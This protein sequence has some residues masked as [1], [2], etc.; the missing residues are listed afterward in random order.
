MP[1]RLIC[2]IVFGGAL[3][4]ALAMPA[5]EAL[6]D[7]R[8]VQPVHERQLISL[9]GYFHPLADAA[10]DRGGASSDMLL[11][12][13]H[14][15][16]GPSKAQDMELDQFLEELHTAGIKV[17]GSGGFSG[18]LNLTCTITPIAA[19]DPAT[20]TLSPPALAL[21]GSDY[22]EFDVYRILNRS[23]HWLQ[24]NPLVTGQRDI[25]RHS[26]GS[27]V[28]RAAQLASYAWLAFDCSPHWRCALRRRGFDRHGGRGNPGTSPGTYTV[29]VT[30]TAG[31]ISA[32]IATLTL[33]VH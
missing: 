29:T 3:L 12:R 13:I 9:H 17:V 20:C 15:T 8:I 6:P 30:G 23:N 5:Q 27:L 24:S 28:S 21:S 10:N 19:N 11:E 31:S 2:S 16:P 26:D 22:P 14:L 33:T 7:P 1:S 4:S 32:T 25:T 18:T